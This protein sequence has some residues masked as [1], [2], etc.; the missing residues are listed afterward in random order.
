LFGV[1]AAVCLAAG[2][3]MAICVKPMQNLMGGVR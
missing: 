3:V 1:T 2:I